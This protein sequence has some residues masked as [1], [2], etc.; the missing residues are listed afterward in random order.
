MTD[1]VKTIRANGDIVLR[2][3]LSKHLKP[4]VVL[5]AIEVA[6]EI[7]TALV[8]KTASYGVEIDPIE[9][10]MPRYELSLIDSNCCI[11]II[12]PMETAMMTIV[13]LEGERIGDRD[14][15]SAR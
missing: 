2:H 4:H 7:Y 6:R 8:A 15:H 11:E 9:R 13:P 3:E 5:K 12:A 14:G 10:Y 1:E